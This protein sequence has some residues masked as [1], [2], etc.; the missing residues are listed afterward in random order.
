MPI[1]ADELEKTVESRSGEKFN[2]IFAINWFLIV[3]FLIFQKKKKNI[4]LKNIRLLN[5]TIFTL[6][7]NLL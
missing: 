5:V 2:S 6:F 7:I 1:I 3:F 4:F